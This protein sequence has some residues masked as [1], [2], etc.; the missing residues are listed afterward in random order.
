MMKLS[1]ILAIN[2]KAGLFKLISKG[3]NNFIVESL[4]DKKR[5]PAFS[6]EGIS[7]LDNISVF[8]YEK[9]LPLVDVFKAIYTKENGGK[10]PD[11]SKDN[12][13]LKTYF[14]EVL[15]NYDKERV[16]A[17]NI[18]KIVIWYNLLHDENMLDFTEEAE[19]LE[20]AGE[21]TETEVTGDETP[22]SIAN[23]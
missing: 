1:E 12:E 19:V 14:E 2:G 10:A 22:E 8:T 23:E 17:H 21:N 5:A 6:H 9:D 3:K 16:Y 13:K 7:T 20:E 4:I 18:K 15:P 11:I